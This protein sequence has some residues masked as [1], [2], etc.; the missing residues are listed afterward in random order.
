MY[1][2][3]DDNYEIRWERMGKTPTDLEGEEFIKRAIAEDVEKEE[4]IF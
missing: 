2:S 4:G 1:F 3:I